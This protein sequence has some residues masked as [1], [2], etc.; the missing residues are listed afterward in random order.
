MSQ[1]GYGNVPISTVHKNE[2]KSSRSQVG[3]V[4]PEMVVE[5]VDLAVDQLVGHET[6][7][8]EDAR[9]RRFLGRFEREGRGFVS[10][11]GSSA[12]AGWSWS[13][14]KFWSADSGA[15]F[16]NVAK[17]RETSTHM[18]SF[19]ILPIDV[20]EPFR[21]RSPGVLPPLRLL[22]PAGIGICNYTSVSGSSMRGC[23][24]PSLATLQQ[25]RTCLVEMDCLV[26]ER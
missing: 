6:G 11:E 21:V 23:D 5:P 1:T 10:A 2:R 18:V 14:S 17:V 15:T 3:V 22:T 8:G 7:F 24:S 9:D 26:Y 20:S 19:L 16:C 13:R 4:D 12:P 25:E